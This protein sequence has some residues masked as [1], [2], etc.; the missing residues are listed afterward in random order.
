MRSSHTRRAGSVSLTSAKPEGAPPASAAPRSLAAASPP[1]QPQQAT[2]PLLAAVGIP[3]GE[4]HADDPDALGGSLVCSAGEM[5]ELSA[6]SYTAWIGGLA[7]RTHSQL[8]D[9]CDSHDA[10]GGADLIGE[11][12]GAGLLTQLP[13][14]GDQPAAWLGAYRIHPQGAGIGNTAESPPR[15]TI[16]DLAG[17]PLLAVDAGLYHVWAMSASTASLA[18]AVAAVTRLTGLTLDELRPA[19]CEGLPYLLANR[20]AYLDRS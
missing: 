7:P 18:E 10:P 5:F 19:V 2:A 16:V 15:Y 6:D 20:A 14:S 1:G 17:Q 12:A 8:R 4:Y 13:A 9:W 11:L 3:L